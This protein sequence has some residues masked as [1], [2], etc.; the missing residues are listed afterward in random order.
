MLSKGDGDVRRT[1]PVEHHPTITSRVGASEGGRSWETGTIGVI[2]PTNSA[3]S[4]TVVLVKKEMASG[5]SA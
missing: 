3:Q 2:K 5:D 1:S 4:S